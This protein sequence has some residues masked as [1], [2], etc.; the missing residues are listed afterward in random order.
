MMMDTEEDISQPD[1][2]EMECLM[3]ERPE[4]KS[5]AAIKWARPDAPLLEPEKQ[6]LIFQQIDIDHYTGYD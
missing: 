1:S 6:T 5:E 3:A 4:I 2:E